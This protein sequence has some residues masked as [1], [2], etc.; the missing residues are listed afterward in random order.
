[1]KKIF[2]AVASF[3]MISSTFVG[4]AAMAQTGVYT[5]TAD[6]FKG[7]PLNCTVSADFASVP[8]KVV[9]GIVP[10]VA[11]CAALSITSN[12]HNFTVIGTT[13][14]VSNVDVNTITG[15]G[16]TGDLVATFDNDVIS[17]NTSIPAR[18]GDLTGDCFIETN[19][20][21]LNN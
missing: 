20:P 4:G 2:S 16:C 12:P 18:P 9:L 14:T 7:I 3:A 6:V 11:S 1:M 10:P 21:H 13:L 8:G 19:A 5:G 15:S 17:I